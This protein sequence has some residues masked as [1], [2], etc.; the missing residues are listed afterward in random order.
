[1]FSA[2]GKLAFPCGM[3]SGFGSRDVSKLFPCFDISSLPPRQLKLVQGE[4]AAEPEPTNAPTFVSCRR[5]MR[6]A[7]ISQPDV[8]GRREIVQRTLTDGTILARSSVQYLE[9]ASFSPD[10]RMLWLMLW[11]TDESTRTRVL[12]IQARDSASN[13]LLSTIPLHRKT[14]GRCG[15]KHSP[16]GSSLAISYR[17]PIDAVPAGEEDPGDRPLTVE[18]WDVGGIG[19]SVVDP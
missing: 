14:F 1:M 2:D 13:R 19:K 9:E 8:D 5:G 12:E 18:I 16:D 7:E 11:R 4:P 3:P 6:Y 17:P 10:G 15:W